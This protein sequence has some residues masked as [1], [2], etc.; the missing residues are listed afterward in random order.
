MI[1]ILPRSGYSPPRVIVNVDM[2]SRVSDL[3]AYIYDIRD[4]ISIRIDFLST[5]YNQQ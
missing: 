4:H 5:I 3:L 2:I 1:D